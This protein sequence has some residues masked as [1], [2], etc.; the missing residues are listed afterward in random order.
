VVLVSSKHNTLCQV[1]VAGL[2]AASPAALNTIVY[3]IDIGA[4]I[5]GTTRISVGWQ[6][7]YSAHVEM[8]A[9]C[10]VDACGLT[11]I[12]IGL[13][14]SSHGSK[15]TITS[16]EWEKLRAALSPMQLWQQQHCI[17]LVHTM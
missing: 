7:K 6:A 11:N 1:V 14:V 9:A 16:I 3:T 5:T 17:E 12:F 4:H 10:S 2:V 8:L 15:A 13:I